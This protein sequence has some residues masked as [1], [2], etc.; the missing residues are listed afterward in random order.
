MDTSKETRACVCV[1]VAV[2][3]KEGAVTPQIC[4]DAVHEQLHI[5]DAVCLRFD[6]RNVLDGLEQRSSLR[7]THC[8]TRLQQ[9]A[10]ISPFY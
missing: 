3:H 10:I 5:R 1:Y 8:L 6:G 2:L 7:R 4:L 9:S